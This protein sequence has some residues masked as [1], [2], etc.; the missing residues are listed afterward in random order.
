MNRR[1]G[2][3]EEFEFEQLPYDWQTDTYAKTQLHVAIAVT[4]WI[5][6]EQQGSVRI[7]TFCTDLMVLKL[8]IN[9]LC[10][11][12]FIESESKM[13]LMVVHSNFH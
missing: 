7:A 11:A 10:I 9:V 12:N 3:I 2:E 4:G 1:V 8:V 5:T 6:G 13:Y